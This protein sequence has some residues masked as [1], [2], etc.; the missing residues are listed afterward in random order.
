MVQQNPD[1]QS[2]LRGFIASY[3]GPRERAILLAADVF[4]FYM[5]LF[6]DS[7][8]A[9]HDRQ[10]INAVLAY[11][12]V[13]QDVMPEEILGPYGL[14]DDLWVASNAYRQIRKS[15]PGEILHDAWQ[16]EGELED[17]MAVVHSECR[18]AVGKK[19][20]AILKMA[21]LT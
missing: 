6:V 10:M 4:A 12:A 7:R 8:V 18:A 5:H 2:I 3:R 20:K 11:F 21:G 17:A 14:L 9:R 13:S 19:G 16:G 15:I 1:Y